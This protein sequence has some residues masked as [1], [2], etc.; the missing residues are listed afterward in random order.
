MDEIAPEYD[1]VVLGTGRYAPPLSIYTQAHLSVRL[2]R[3]CT[4]RVN[5]A[6]ITEC[7]LCAD[8]M[9]R[10]MSV[11]G[12]KVLHIDRND[13]YGGYVFDLEMRFV[14]YSSLM[15][16]RSSLG[17]HRICELNLASNIIIY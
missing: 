17:Q 8:L 1:V 9:C 2:D 3:M 16:Q 10:V 6:S 7:V 15:L 13:H 14:L 12:K 11:K 4:L 5:I